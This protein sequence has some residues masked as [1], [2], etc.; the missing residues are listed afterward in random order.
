MA[1]AIVEYLDDPQTGIDRWPYGFDGSLSEDGNRLRTAIHT[2]HIRLLESCLVT[3]GLSSMGTTVVA[4]LEHGGRL[5]VAW[6]GDSR[7][8]LCGSTGLRQLTRDD[9]WIE[10]ALLE[11]PE[12][13]LE[14]LKRHPLRNAL[15]NVLGTASHLDVHV[16]DVRLEGDDVVALTTDGIHGVLDERDLTHLLSRQ[17]DP[18]RAAADLVAAAVGV[19]S[20]DDCTAVIARS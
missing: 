12:A 15:T 7:L 20:S 1:D 13:D 3:P 18:A 16:V 17:V 10:A 5:A 11:H 19:G 9:S 14:T 8:Y 2:A 4:A 6:V